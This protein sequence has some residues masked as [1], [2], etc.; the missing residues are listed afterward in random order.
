L[1]SSSFH[2]PQSIATV[3]GRHAAL[4]ESAISL[5]HP[6]M[7]Q[8]AR[9]ICK[10]ASDILRFYNDIPLSGELIDQM[11]KLKYN[12]DNVYHPIG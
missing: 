12:N 7:H 5:I 4:A 1:L 8:I 6:A 2:P 10:Y 3:D 9:Q 11:H